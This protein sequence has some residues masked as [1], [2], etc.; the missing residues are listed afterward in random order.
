MGALLAGCQGL[1]TVADLGTA[2]GTATGTISPEQADSISKSA[3]AV[4][5]SFQ[6]ITPEQEYYIGRTVGAIV[7]SKYGPYDVPAVNRYINL[8]GQTLARASDSPET[9][10]GYHFLIQDSEEINALAAPGGL[11]FITRGMLKCCPHEAA[12]AAVLAHEIGHVESKHGLQAIKTSRVTAALTTIGVE[13]SK[14]LGGEQLADLTRTFEGSITDITQTLVNSG[15]SRAFENQAD[16][17]AVKILKRVGYDPNG[18]IDMLKTMQ[19]RLKP[20]RRDFAATHPSPASRITEVQPQIGPYAA[21]KP[22]AVQQER[23]I[24]ALRSV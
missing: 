11:V 2:I 13:G 4:A 15:Y 14:Q 12:V 17:A 5:H 24:N 21:V 10:G 1:E 9:F 20:G 18:L 23:F 3:R 6:D 8:L 19:T 22:P 16:R 7:L